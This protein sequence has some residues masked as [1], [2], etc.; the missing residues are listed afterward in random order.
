MENLPD[1]IRY[2]IYAYEHQLKYC[3]VMNELLNGV[4]HLIIQFKLKRNKKH[5]KLLNLKHCCDIFYTDNEQRCSFS[6][7]LYIC[8]DEMDLNDNQTITT[9]NGRY[10]AFL[11]DIH[12]GLPFWYRIDFLRSLGINCLD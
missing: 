5:A 12:M 11:Y 3:D 8:P 1:V 7:P 10:C 6:F 9:M 4:D 2:K